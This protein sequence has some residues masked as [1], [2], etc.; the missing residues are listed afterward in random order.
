[1][2]FAIRINYSQ[3][4]KR[5]GGGGGERCELL[6]FGYD[7]YPFPFHFEVI[8]ANTGLP[9]LSVAEKIPSLS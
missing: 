9:A 2:L 6:Q 7:L 3:A 8:R 5:R 1:M 4:R